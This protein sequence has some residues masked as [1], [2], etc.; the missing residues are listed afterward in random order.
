MDLNMTDVAWSRQRKAG[1][2]TW[3]MEAGGGGTRLD[4]GRAGEASIA[5]VDSASPRASREVA[6][7]IFSD[8]IGA[9]FVALSVLYHFSLK[10]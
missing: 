8:P 4:R 5:G 1:R 3:G 9:I 2:K 10:M 6:I 7:V